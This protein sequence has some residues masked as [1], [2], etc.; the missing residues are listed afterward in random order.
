[1]AVRNMVR[2]H[3]GSGLVIGLHH[4]SGLF[5]DSR[6]CDSKQRAASLNL[7]FLALFILLGYD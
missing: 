6:F 3:C 1:M 5:Q 7:Q 4:L 2:G